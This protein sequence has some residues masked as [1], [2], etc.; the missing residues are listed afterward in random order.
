MIQSRDLS[1]ERNT[2]CLE[3]CKSFESGANS[4]CTDRD[5]SIWQ[6]CRSPHA[7]KSQRE[8]VWT[9]VNSGSSMSQTTESAREE[10]FEWNTF[11]SPFSSAAHVLQTPERSKEGSDKSPHGFMCPSTP[12]SS[13]SLFNEKLTYSPPL[14]DIDLNFF[15]PTKSLGV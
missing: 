15:L 1:P 5:S 9:R 2:N 12:V 13:L 8:F 10:R 14:G 6:Q 4:F 7:G 11:L 3:H